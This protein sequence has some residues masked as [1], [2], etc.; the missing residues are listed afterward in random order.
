MKNKLNILILSAYP[1]SYSGNLGGD[2]FD[3]L[4][5]AGHNVTYGYDG[6]E[7]QHAS[8]M[9]YFESMKKRTFIQKI[10]SKIHKLIYGTANRNGY[11]FLIE[12][13]LHPNLPSRCNACQASPTRDKHV[14]PR[15][16]R[17]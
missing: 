4:I 7:D 12:D 13:E 6:I 17:G 5:R 1:K 8:V 9:N 16:L 10:C 15:L 2:I 11:Y 14:F 3:A